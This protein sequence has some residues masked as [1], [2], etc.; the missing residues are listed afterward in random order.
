MKIL[1]F[2]VGIKNLAYCLADTSLKQIIKWEV[3]NVINTEFP[4]ISCKKSDKTRSAIFYQY[5]PTIDG[6]ASSEQIHLCGVCIKKKPYKDWYKKSTIPIAE[7]TIN[8]YKIGKLR[9]FVKANKIILEKGDNIENIRSKVSDYA[10]E[11][12]W[13]TIDIK[14]A[15]DIDLITVGRGIKEH[16][17]LI[18][19]GGK[20]N[21]YWPDMVLIEN[22]ISPI[23]NRMK[24]V[25]GMLAQ[26]FIC[27]DLT[28]PINFV[29]AS[30]KL[31]YFVDKEAMEYY[32]ARKNSAVEVCTL[33][34]NSDDGWVNEQK[35]QWITKFISHKKND[36]L[37][38]AY[39]QLLW[40]C[41]EKKGFEKP[42]IK[43]K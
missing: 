13:L 32:K 7:D 36:D 26:Y 38:D 11:N 35:D 22:Q 42:N 40:Y 37:A 31:K 20:A 27:N 41:I 4:C 9:E 39:L 3:A 24:T 10:K 18:F 19:M 17:D 5:E 25:Q 34:L 30:N 2:D 12:C 23:A 21:P 8:V 16:F 15:N 28:I 43:K 6:E 33:L 29:S 1:S 14:K